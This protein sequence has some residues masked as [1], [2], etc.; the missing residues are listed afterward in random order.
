VGF[1]NPVWLL[2]EPSRT[3]VPVERRAPDSSW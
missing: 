3:P 2:R 1:S